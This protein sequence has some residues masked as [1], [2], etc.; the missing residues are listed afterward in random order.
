MTKKV[1]YRSYVVTV[2][3]RV[4][5]RMPVGRWSMVRV[6]GVSARG[7][8]VLAKAIV[9]APATATATVRKD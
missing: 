8:R 3:W 6:D 7:A 4:A 9:G 5:H 1:V 2:K